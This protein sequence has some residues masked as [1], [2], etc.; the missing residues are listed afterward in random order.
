M[1]WIRIALLGIGLWSPSLLWPGVYEALTF[2]M[3]IGLGLGLGLGAL[4]VFIG[5]Q[6][7]SQS[8]NRGAPR[9]GAGRRPEF[10]YPT[11]P[12]PVIVP[13]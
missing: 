5:M 4:M 12:A 13:R 8:Q 11:Y 6:Q 1:K 9:T 7:I 3:M 10:D 2:P